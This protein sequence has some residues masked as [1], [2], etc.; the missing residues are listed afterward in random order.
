M[1]RQFK[2]NRRELNLERMFETRSDA[3]ERVG[4]SIDV[5]E[6]ES[7]RAKRHRSFSSRC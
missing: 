1:P 3:W 4:L 5:D 7:Q 2:P 6:R